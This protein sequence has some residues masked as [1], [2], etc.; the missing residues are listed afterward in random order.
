[1]KTYQIVIEQ[2]AIYEVQADSYESAEDIAWERFDPDHLCA[3][4]TAEILVIENE[5]E[6]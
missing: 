3:P 2:H 1:M 6:N 4:L 5:S